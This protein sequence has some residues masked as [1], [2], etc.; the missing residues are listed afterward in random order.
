MADSA[1]EV[2]TRALSGH[3][4]NENA[5]IET[6][7]KWNH[8]EKKLFRKKSSHFFSEDERSFERWEEHGMRLLKHE[9][10]RFKNAVV[11]WTTHPWERDARLVK[12]ALSKGHH[13]QNINILIEVACT[14]TSDELLGARKAYHSLFDHSIEEDVASHLNGPERKLLVALMSAYRYEGPKY[15]EEIAK[16]EAKKFA[17]SIKEANSKKSSLIEDEEIVRILST[18]SKHFLHALY[19]HYNEISAGRSIDEDLH[20]DLRLQEAVLCLTNPVKYFTQ[21]LDVSLKADADKKIKKVLTRVVVT[22][23]DNDMKEIKVEFKKQFGVS[24][25]EKIGSVCNG[26]YKDFLITLLARSD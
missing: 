10:M 18:R 24:L 4:I 26:S 13:G 5:M 16:S 22:R 11:L 17:H 7:G 19:K 12:E 20:G 6:L 21:L 23:A 25:A 9:F 2:L 8:E 3:G 15:K 1:I 14:R